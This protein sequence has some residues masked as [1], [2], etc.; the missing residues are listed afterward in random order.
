MHVIGTAGH[1]DHGKSALVAAL[2]GIQPDRLKEEQQRQMTIDL[3]YAWL[4]LPGGE[5]VGIV[6]VPGHRDFI[7]NMLAGAGEIDAALLVIAANEGIMPQTR[8]HLAIL[9]ALE[10]RDGIIVLTKVDLANEP[11][12]LD[13]LEQTVRGEVENTTLATWPVVRVSS[14]TGQGIE[15][16]KQ[17]IAE[18]LSFR[19][20]RPDVGQP[21]LPI[22]RVFT[23]SGF[24]VVVTGT[25]SAGQLRVGE[26]VEVLPLGIRGRI[27]GLQSYKQKVEAALP[28][29]RVAV[30]LTGV[31][32][33]DLQRGNVLAHPGQYSITQRLDVHFCLVKDA[34]YDLRHDTVVKLFLG[35]SVTAARVR[36][37]GVEVLH[38]GETGWL[39]L[40]L[41]VPVVAERGD[42]YLLWRPSPGG[43]LGGGEIVIPEPAER[44]KRF[45][46]AIIQRLE[47]YLHGAPDEVLYQAALTVGVTDVAGLASLA[48]LDLPI[49][50]EAVGKLVASGLL[51]T[52]G[53]QG[54]NLDKALFL[55][56]VQWDKEA[57]EILQAVR[58]FHHNHPLR[59]GMPREELKSK[60]KVSIRV[61]LAYLDQLELEKALVN[62]GSVVAVPEFTI[63]LSMQEQKAVD[64]LLARFRQVPYSPPSVKDCQAAVGEEVFLSLLDQK[65]LVQLSQE[66]VVSG[67]VYQEWLL[68]VRRHFAQHSTL[69]VVELRDAFDTSRKYALAFLEHLDAQGL[70][71]RDGNFHKLRKIVAG[72]TN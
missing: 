45:D 63:K 60:L 55:P 36:L 58:Q 16:L 64:A 21:R 32:I 25:L 13:G 9:D 50:R 62:I 46:P 40:E 8:E 70:T 22:D 53:N 33:E 43:L 20:P 42:R 4:T 65:V 54:Q 10:V 67:E 61:F 44:H 48:K 47:S 31:G 27:R 18:C 52:L 24:G 57:A 49:A 19:P 39:Q 6:D 71:Q 11:T 26:E 7:E 3:G 37:L 12:I 17:A 28:G 72:S 38:P 68:F 29:S 69:T 66:V 2:T 35:T 51:V 15:D 41:S 59:R 56:K 1:V 14:K 23:L 34:R 30:N 5:Q